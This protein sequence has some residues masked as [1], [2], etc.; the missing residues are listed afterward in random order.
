MKKLFSLSALLL[1]GF[2]SVASAFPKHTFH[3]RI[4]DMDRPGHQSLY[5]E[6]EDKDLDAGIGEI[7]LSN[8]HVPRNVGAPI[9]LGQDDCG[10]IDAPCTTYVSPS[11]QP[12]KK[13]RARAEIHWTVNRMRPE[14]IISEIKIDMGRSGAVHAVMTEHPDKHDNAAAKITANV[15]GFFYPHGVKAECSYFKATG[16]RGRPI[17]T[18]SN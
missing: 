15:M 13:A 9:Q 1:F 5:F 6:I 8:W 2:A 18:G 11:W 4:G 14:R 12:F 3:C 10:M 16:S 7:T 17:M